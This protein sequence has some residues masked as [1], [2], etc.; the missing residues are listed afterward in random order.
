MNTLRFTSVFC[1]A[2]AIWA[3]SPTSVGAALPIDLEVAKE[4]GTPLTAPQEWARLL[5]RMGLG[6]VR[7]RDV[8]SGERPKLDTKKQGNNTRYH[9]LAI[10]NQRNELVL[11]GRRFQVGDRH[12]LQKYLEQLP[13]QAAYNAEE[14]GRFGLTEK[15][16]RLVYAELSQP[17]G[18]STVAKPASEVLARLEKSITLPVVRLNGFM[19]T[20][21]YI[22]IF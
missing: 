10:L 1:C 21:L 15:Q 17:V 16:F 22:P 12:A 20:N 19:Y 3:M 13:A 8:R 14:R 2:L 4:P 5:G 6:S 11:P 18:F 7:L 9:L